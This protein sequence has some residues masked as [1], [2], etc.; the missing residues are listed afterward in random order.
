MH[1]C[2]DACG[3]VKS[4]AGW[5]GETILKVCF[6][7]KELLREYM[8]SHDSIG[9][10]WPNQVDPF[11]HFVDRLLLFIMVENF[12]GNTKTNSLMKALQQ[13]QIQIAI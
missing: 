11:K 4:Y 5:D 1:V 9:C 10:A 7:L 6:S 8:T 13:L 3:G 12:E 2:I